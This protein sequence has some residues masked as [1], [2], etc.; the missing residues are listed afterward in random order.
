MEERFR[1]EREIGSRRALLVTIG[2]ALLGALA[3]E[4]CRAT[5]FCKCGHLAHDVTWL[6]KI[7]ETWKVLPLLAIIASIDVHG[8]VSLFHLA[9]V[10]AVGLS[11][12]R[13]IDGY[14][15]SPLP[16]VGIAIAGCAALVIERKIFLG[17][18][19]SAGD[20]GDRARP[21]DEAGT[22]AEVSG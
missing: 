9:F 20:D 10:G 15:S 12:F 3:W 22:G 19:G 18:M 7:V 1:V 8:R 11:T 5:H 17:G 16:T 21:H 14:G 13:W 4:V 2:F 6:D